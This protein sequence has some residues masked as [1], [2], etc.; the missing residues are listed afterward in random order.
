MKWHRVFIM[1]SLSALGFAGTS[2]WYRVTT[3]AVAVQEAHQT[4]A[5]PADIQEELRKRPVNHQLW[6]TLEVGQ[7]IFNGEPVRTSE[8]GHA[9]LNLAEDG[10]QVEWMATP[11]W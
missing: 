2:Y 8:R 7:P 6:Q 4:V 3:P 10:R 1:G 11:W 9:V 5:V